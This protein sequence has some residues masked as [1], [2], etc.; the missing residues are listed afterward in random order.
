[1]LL[2]VTFIGWIVLRYSR[3]YLDGEKRQTYFTIWLLSTLAAVLLLVQSGNLVQLVVA[4]IA[5]SFCLHRLL[6]FYPE[7]RRR[8]TGRPQ[9]V[10]H[11]AYRRSGA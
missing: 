1:M 5:T 3:T 11:G 7:R 2:L 9:E 8:T 4:W 6:L 10:R